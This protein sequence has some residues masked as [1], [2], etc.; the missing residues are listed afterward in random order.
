MFTDHAIA[1]RERIRRNPPIIFAELKLPNKIPGIIPDIEI[2]G[3]MSSATLI[4]FLKGI[5]V[6]I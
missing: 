6:T 3:I 1:L 4:I 2:K 5:V